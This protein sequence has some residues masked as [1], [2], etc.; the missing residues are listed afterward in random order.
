MPPNTQKQIIFSGNTAANLKSKSTSHRQQQPSEGTLLMSDSEDPFMDSP[1]SVSGETSMSSNGNAFSGKKQVAVSSFLQQGEDEETSIRRS[2]AAIRSDGSFSEPQNYAAMVRSKYF[3]TQHLAS[4]N[5]HNSCDY[6]STDDEIKNM[7]F[8]E[9]FESDGYE[10]TP[11]HTPLQP[12]QR[13]NIHTRNHG[14]PGHDDWMN[15]PHQDQKIPGGLAGTGT[16]P[17]TLYAGSEAVLHTTQNGEDGFANETAGVLSPLHSEMM[18][19]MSSGRNT[20]TSQFTADA[21]AGSV[22]SSVA[23]SLLRSSAGSVNQP[24]SLLS[25][26]PVLYSAIGSLEQINTGSLRNLSRRL[27]APARDFCQ[28]GANQQSTLIP[29]LNYRKSLLGAFSNSELQTQQAN[30]SSDSKD[31]NNSNSVATV[32]LKGATKIDGEEVFGVLKKKNSKGREKKEEENASKESHTRSHSTASA[33]TT[34]KE[35]KHDK[36]VSYDPALKSKKKNK[37]PIEMFR[38]SSDA[39]TPRIE[40]KSIQYRAAEAR[41]P[42]QQM[43]SPMGTLQR[44]NFRDAL[45]R[46][47]MIIH[48]HV[49]KIESRFEGQGDGKLATDD[50]LFKTSMK[51]LFNEDT[52]RTPTYTCTM[53]RI[54]MARPGMAYGLRKIRV[55]YDIPSETEIYE[56][57]HQLF[58]SVQLSSECSIVCLIYVERLMEQAKVPL[59]ACTWRPIFMCGLLLA[60][61]VWQDLSSWN[62]EFASVYPQFSLEAINRLEL[63]FLRNVKWDLYISSSLYAKYYFALRS[64]VEKQDFRQRYNRLVGGVDTVA[65]SEALKVQKRTEQV[66]EEA[67]LQLSRSM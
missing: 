22:S 3:D 66:K 5:H 61:K 1:A 44:P 39:Y 55:A 15:G 19:A 53:V 58:N 30:P 31:S 36:K 7:D 10:T 57:G 4:A 21:V 27:H 43:A 28:L 67:L 34:K 13:N 46:V 65:Q 23:S 62:I 14:D 56:F 64:L 40:R 6:L 45:R 41:T 47:A 11:T 32:S 52:Y 59:L 2:S 38:P 51:D 8:S 54:P 50:G 26:Q 17:L 12:G 37:G 60:S 35:T 33:S 9:M 42:V 49:V 48:Q 25:K 29:P 24:S 63:N 16:P 20:P 18:D